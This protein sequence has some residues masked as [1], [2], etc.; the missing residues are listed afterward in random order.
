VDR[1]YQC[2]LVQDACASADAYAHE[3]ALHMVTAEDGVF[4]VLARLEDVVQGLGTLKQAAG[5]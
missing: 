2:L 1:K 5:R 3:A 4:G